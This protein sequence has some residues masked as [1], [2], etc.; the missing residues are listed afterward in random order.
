[1]RKELRPSCRAF[2]AG[3]QATPRIATPPPAAEPQ[4]VEKPQGA[5]VMHDRAG[6]SCVTVW[7]PLR[8]FHGSSLS[9]KGHGPGLASEG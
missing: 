8:N 6:Q 7:P 9:C 3:D 1:M 5:H 2:G 4:G